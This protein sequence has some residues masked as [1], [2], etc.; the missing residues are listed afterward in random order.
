MSDKKS[1][2]KKEIPKLDKESMKRFINTLDEKGLSHLRLLNNNHLVMENSTLTAQTILLALTRIESM[3]KAIII[4][5][6][7]KIE[8]PTKETKELREST[9]LHVG[10]L[11]KLLEFNYVALVKHEN[12]GQTASEPMPGS[13]N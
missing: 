1:D 4:L 2:G 11:S 7:P 9:Y 13:M 6:D 12:M 3:L 8:L 10:Q 5:T